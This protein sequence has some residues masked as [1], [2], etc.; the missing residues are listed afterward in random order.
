MRTLTS[1]KSKYKGYVYV[2]ELDEKFFLLRPDPEPEDGNDDTD[3]D[4]AE[5]ETVELCD[6]DGSC[7]DV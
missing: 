3:D 2:E 5:D 4:D 6:E 1:S 7:R